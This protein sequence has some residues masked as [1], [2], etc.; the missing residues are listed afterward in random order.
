MHGKM[1]LTSQETDTVYLLLHLLCDF[2]ARPGLLASAFQPR[3]ALSS[4]P[5]P[6]QT[7]LSAVSQVGVTTPVIPSALQTLSSMPS[8]SAAPSPTAGAL[9]NGNSFVAADGLEQTLM[10]PMLSGPCAHLFYLYRPIV[11]LLSLDAGSLETET[12]A[13]GMS[14]H[15]LVQDCLR[16]IGE[17]LGVWQ[18]SYF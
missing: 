5:Q 4:P 7:Q 3:S 2:K 14:L 8:F 1:P 18:L 15:Q 12:M 10:L 9:L 16:K 13:A 11:S 17:A 6:L